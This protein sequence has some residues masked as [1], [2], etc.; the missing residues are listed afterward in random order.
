MI[1]F[2][3]M[4]YK[5]INAK[6]FFNDLFSKFFFF[7]NL[8]KSFFFKSE[9]KFIKPADVLFIGN[10]FNKSIIQNGK[11]YSYLMDPLVKLA[12]KSGFSTLCLSNPYSRLYCNQSFSK[13]ININF[14]FLFA[15]IISFFNSSDALLNFWKKIFIKV[16]PK[17]IIC[18]QPSKEMSAAAKILKIRIYDLQHGLIP[19]QSDNYYNIKR[20][21]KY[22][23]IKISVIFLC[24]DVVSKKNIQKILPNKNVILLGHPMLLDFFALNNNQKIKIFKKYSKFFLIN[25]PVILITLQPNYFSYIDI[26][27]HIIK[28]INI[29]VTQRGWQLW[30]RF[31]PAQSFNK[32]K[33]ILYKLW[34]E[35]TNLIISS[36]DVV[37][38]TN[39]PF[40]LLMKKTNVHITNY[41]SCILESKI[42]KVPSFL[43]VSSN[44]SVIKFI[45]SYLK[46]NFT[47][48]L[49]SNVERNLLLFDKYKTT[50]NNYIKNYTFLK[51]SNTTEKKFINLLKLKK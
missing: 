22:K 11:F 51:N 30:V 47:F 8:T 7:L 50:N 20:H 17:L 28:L 18:I 26:P 44:D 10:D 33:K 15:Y 32:S 24:W 16:K 13:S 45:N 40:F 41:S 5:F 12:N 49:T 1:N 25:K 34:Q 19:S 9:F 23:K 42:F 37:D 6:I 2:F 21:T 39:E 36:G 43:W 31:H 35:K 29:L 27:N 4:R 48:L 3:I 38:V 46:N 14:E